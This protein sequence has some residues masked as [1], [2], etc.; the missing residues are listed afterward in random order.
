MKGLRNN[1]DYK[2]ALGASLP[3]H[4]HDITHPCRAVNEGHPV[5]IQGHIQ[6]YRVFQIYSCLSR[7]DGDGNYNQ[8]QTL[9]G[10]RWISHLPGV[11]PGMAW[12]LSCNPFTG[13]C[14][15]PSQALGLCCE[16]V[17]TGKTMASGVP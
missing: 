8:S 4:N 16:S 6:G 15:C 7:R 3:A 2:Q 12:H 9:G 11:P 5:L 10:L 14:H 1:K 13:L 17:P